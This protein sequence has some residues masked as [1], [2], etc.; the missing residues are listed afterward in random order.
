MTESI[1]NEPCARKRPQNAGLSLLQRLPRTLRELQLNC[2]DVGQ[3]ADFDTTVLL[4]KDL[5]DHCNSNGLFPHLK[6]LD[7]SGWFELQTNPYVKSEI[8]ELKEYIKQAGV[9]GIYSTH[10][11]DTLFE[12]YKDSGTG[13][14]PWKKTSE[15]MYEHKDNPKFF[16]NYR[17][18]VE[19]AQRNRLA[20]EELAFEEELTN[21]L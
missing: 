11:R 1:P 12:D 15:E 18:Y 13:T 9:K 7:L 14:W 4:I 8:S 16:W 20:Q 10:Y 6:T 2:L 3:L 21:T 5:V 17:L 19:D